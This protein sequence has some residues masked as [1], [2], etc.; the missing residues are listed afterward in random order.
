MSKRRPK[1]CHCKKLFVVP[2]GHSPPRG[3]P[4]IGNI[5]VA[6]RPKFTPAERKPQF[7]VFIS[8]RPPASTVLQIGRCFRL[9]VRLVAF[10]QGAEGLDV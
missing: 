1:D 3:L 8:P 2:F 7:A 5:R 9:L 6:G 10:G 4:H